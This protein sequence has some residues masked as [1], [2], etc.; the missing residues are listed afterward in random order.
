MNLCPLPGLSVFVPGYMQVNRYTGTGLRRVSHH[1][2]G[3]K[4]RCT[5]TRIPAARARTPYPSI[6][7][8]VPVYPPPVPVNSLNSKFKKNPPGSHQITCRTREPVS[9]EPIPV[10]TFFLINFKFYSLQSKLYKYT[11]LP[12]NIFTFSQSLNLLFSQYNIILNF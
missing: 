6:P 3:K 12:L 10:R 9:T 5:R 11:P 1:F 7:L 4:T 2:F 8:H